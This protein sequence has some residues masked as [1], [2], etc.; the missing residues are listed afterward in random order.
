MI[1]PALKNALRNLRSV[2]SQR[3]T[4]ADPVE[5]ADW[6]DKMGEA[7]DVLATVL[8]FEEDRIKARAEAEAARAQAAEIRGRGEVI[9]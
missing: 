4:G 6:R 3:P 7:L 9:S 5:F 1:D 8:L 2:R